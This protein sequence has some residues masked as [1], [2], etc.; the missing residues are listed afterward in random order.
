MKNRKTQFQKKIEKQNETKFD[1]ICNDFERHCSLGWER[2]PQIE[3]IQQWILFRWVFFR[4]FPF[5]F[6]MLPIQI[7]IIGYQNEATLKFT[8]RGQFVWIWCRHDSKDYSIGS[9]WTLL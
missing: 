8:N 9:E 7:H 2:K 4:E 6:E 3:T 1:K 5:L